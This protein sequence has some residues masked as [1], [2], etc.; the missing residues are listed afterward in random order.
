MARYVTPHGQKVLGNEYFINIYM[1]IALDL[2]YVIRFYRRRF[3]KASI[4]GE[5]LSLLGK[6]KELWERPFDA[7]G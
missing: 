2:F 7:R 6:D 4:K 5:F 3:S 1:Y